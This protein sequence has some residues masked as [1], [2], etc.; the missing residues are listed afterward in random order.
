MDSGIENV[1]AETVIVLVVIG[2]YDVGVG[3]KGDLSSDG[4]IKT[5]NL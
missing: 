2:R 5:S 3:G 4:N 1:S